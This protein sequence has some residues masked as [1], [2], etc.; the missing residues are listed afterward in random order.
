MSQQQEQQLREQKNE[1]DCVRSIGERD[2]QEAE[3]D[4]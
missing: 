1:A 2:L 3:D 4:L